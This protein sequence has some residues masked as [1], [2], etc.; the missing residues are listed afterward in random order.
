[1]YRIIRFGT[2]NLEYSNQVEDIGSGAVPT[3]Y[4]VL[5]GGGALDGFGL[6]EKNPGLVERVK[7]LRL[8]AKTKEELEGIY[9]NLLSL[10]GK[11]DKLYRRTS[12]GVIEWMYARCVEVSASRTYEQTKFRLIQ[13]VSLKF[14]CQEVFWR[15]FFKGRLFFDSGFYFDSGLFFDSVRSFDLTTSP[16]SIDLVV[17]DAP[18]AAPVLAILITVNAG[19]AA[20]SDIVIQRSGGEVLT[21]NG[22]VP[23]GGSLTIDTGIMQVTC[24]DLDNAYDYLG[25]SSTADLAAWFSLLPGENDIEVVFSGGGAGRSIEFAY[26]EG[27]Y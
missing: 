1:M 21:F 8:T 26:Y 11:K 19:D 7:S 18:G 22:T 13:D 6:E 12:Q 27:R 2:T 9:F 17:D 24:T 23:A 4:Q 16:T 20:M 3:N 14:A 5:P 15:R 25:L 10:R